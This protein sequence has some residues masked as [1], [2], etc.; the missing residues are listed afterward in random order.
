MKTV[1]RKPTCAR[2]GDPRP[3]R[4]QLAARRGGVQFRPTDG[5]PLVTLYQR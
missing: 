1:T 3:P 4:R 2:Q 5:V